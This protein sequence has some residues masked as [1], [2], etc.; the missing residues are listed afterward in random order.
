[1]AAAVSHHSLTFFW[2]GAPESDTKNRALAYICL[3]YEQN[4]YAAFLSPPEALTSEFT[5]LKFKVKDQNQERDLLALDLTLD[6]IR[7][8]KLELYLA[9]L[10]TKKFTFGNDQEGITKLC[11]DVP[12]TFPAELSP[13]ATEFQLFLTSNHCMGFSAELRVKT[14]VGAAA[15]ATQLQVSNAGPQAAAGAGAGVSPPPGAAA[16][17][18]T[19]VDVPGAALIAGKAP[20]KPSLSPALDLVWQRVMEYHTDATKISVY[21]SLLQERSLEQLNALLK[22]ANSLPQ[23]EEVLEVI[24][25]IVSASV[26]KEWQ[27]K[28]DEVARLI[29]AGEL[30]KA[31]VEAR[32]LERYNRKY[33]KLIAAAWLAKATQQGLAKAVGLLPEMRGSDRKELDQAIRQVMATHLPAS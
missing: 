13:N 26:A 14:S 10:Q 5:Q 28:I 33:L 32:P 6:K 18:A 9:R 3:A 19:K 12:I 7:N 2:K 29:K 21:I 23:T 11:V 27:P 1:M 16:A 25:V 31:L 24:S 15:A 4:A 30:E 8:L 20:T 17:A 22:E